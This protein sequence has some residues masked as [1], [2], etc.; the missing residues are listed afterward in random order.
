MTLADIQRR[1]TLILR[2]EGDRDTQLRPVIHTEMCR[3]MTQQEE[4]NEHVRKFLRWN[5]G[6]RKVMNGN[7]VERR[8][9]VLVP[10][11]RTT[12]SIAWSI[13]SRK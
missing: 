4:G 2:A 7:G 3:E 6:L 1:L 10:L 12:F 8:P 9:H 11:D 5:G 13:S